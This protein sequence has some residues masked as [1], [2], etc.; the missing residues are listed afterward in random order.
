MKRFDLWTLCQPSLIRK[1]CAQSRRPMGTMR[2]DCS[3]SLFEGSQQRSA[4]SSE[5]L[6][7]WVESALSCMNCETF[8]AELNSGH[9]SG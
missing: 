6:K 8:S 9:L 2:Q 4:M 7:T 3:R 1:P 5:D